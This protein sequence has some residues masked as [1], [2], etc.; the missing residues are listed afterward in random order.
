[1]FDF[2]LGEYIVTPLISTMCKFFNSINTEN[3]CSRIKEFNKGFLSAWT[4]IRTAIL[5]SGY[6]PRNKI[7]V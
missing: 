2:K 6:S 7:F 3:L 1:M 5:W 4:S